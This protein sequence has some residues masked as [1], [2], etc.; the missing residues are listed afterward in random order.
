MS[1]CW[2]WQV[3]CKAEEAASKVA[4]NVVVTWGR[5]VMEA[6][7]HALV[8]IGTYWVGVDT[9]SV[10]E[11]SSPAR[12]V[13]D[14]TA[15]LA[16]VIVVGSLMVAAIYLM[17]SMRG[18][19]IRKIVSGVLR[20]IIISGAALTVAQLLISVSDSLATWFLDRADDSMDGSFATR[21]LD[22]GALSPGAIGWL[23]IILG[24]LVGILANLVQI[25]VMEVR[26]AILPLVVGL[27]PLAASAAVLDWG[28][29]WLSRL[30]AWVVSFVMMKPAAA[31]VYG[32][33]IKTASG[34]G[35]ALGGFIRGIILMLLAA[36]ALPALIRLI[37]PAAS[38][39]ASGGGAGAL[40]AGAGAMATG[41]MQV[42]RS[43]GGRGP[44]GT[45]TAG[46]EEGPTG[47]SGTGGG[48]GGSGSPGGR[49]PSGAD[50][51]GATG[52]AGTT[53]TAGG[54]GAQGVASSGA[55]SGSA[56]AA[57]S[58]SAAG[59]GGAAAAGAATGG[60]ATVVMVGA[61]A[62]QAGARTARSAGEDAAGQGPSG[63]EE[64][65]R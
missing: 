43:G 21:L 63:A 17:W 30:T 58:S 9:P 22:I 46:A 60:V 48:S 7:D 55:G 44:S 61:Q 14:S 64:V 39:V 42:S 6:L 57:G 11:E 1:D 13:V 26:G 51:A 41:A 25:G 54:T 5:S 56:A 37:V 10:S 32:V 8:K 28:R 50:A 16:G 49:G 45:D 33:A 24:G 3:E 27:I 2:F 52:A 34:E 31:I 40:A 29:Q 15:W 38:A 62:A 20:M 4:E 47:A 23:T 65:A 35:D 19:E 53:G 59:A 18:E 36:V 12:Y